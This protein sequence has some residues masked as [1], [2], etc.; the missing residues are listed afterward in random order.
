MPKKLIPKTTLLCDDNISDYDLI[1]KNSGL[2]ESPILFSLPTSIGFSKEIDKKLDNTELIFVNINEKE[3]YFNFKEEFL[4]N[5]NELLQI[6]Y[7][8][9]FSN[10]L[11]HEYPLDK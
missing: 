7:K 2:L 3:I 11:T 6:N 10:N 9:K 4:F 1:N 8:P 5:S